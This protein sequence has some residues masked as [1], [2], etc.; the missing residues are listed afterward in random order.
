MAKKILTAILAA[1]AAVCLAGCSKDYVMTAEDLAIQKSIVGY[2]AADDSTGANLY[3]DY[4]MLTAMMV[5]EFTD[6]FK[7]LTH[8]C[9]LDEGYVMTYE[10][11]SY[12]FEDEKF[13]VVVNGVASYAKISVNEDGSKMF[14]ITND[15]TDTYLRVSDEKANELSIPSYNPGTWAETGSAPDTSDASNSD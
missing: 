3:D 2:W 7:S 1:A 9:Y 10:P 13:K 6:D 11:V 14:W 4:G 15:R 5:V 12:T 8:I